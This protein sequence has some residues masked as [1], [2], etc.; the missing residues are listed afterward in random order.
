VRHSLWFFIGAL[1]S[2]YA[3]LILGAGISEVLRGTSTGIALPQLHANIWWGAGIL[4]LGLA[5]VIKDWPW[6]EDPDQKGL[7]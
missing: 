2:V 6:R 7:N 1:L 3:V 4:P 5:F